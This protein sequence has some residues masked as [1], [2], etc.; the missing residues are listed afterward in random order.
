MFLWRNKQNYPLII[1]KYSSVPLHGSCY[2]R[3]ASDE[4]YQKQ[5]GI[6]LNRDKVKL[7]EPPYT[8][9]DGSK[10]EIPQVVRYELPHQQNDICTQRRLRS[11]SASAQSDQSLCCALNWVAKDPSF[12]HADSKDSV[13]TGQMPR[14]IWVFG[15]C[16]F[17]FVGFVIRR[18]TCV[19]LFEHSICI[20]RKASTISDGWNFLIRIYCRKKT[21]LY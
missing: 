8:N 12:L 3:M 13:Q 19:V 6:I 2:F 15:G 17:H 20:T 7:W 4:H 9:K 21:S 10:G 18:L 11:A 14:L 5:L 1:T 16:T